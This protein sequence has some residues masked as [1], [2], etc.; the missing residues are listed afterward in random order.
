M[1]VEYEPLALGGFVVAAVLIWNWIRVRIRVR[2][3]ET[4]VQKML[5]EISLLQIQESRRLI[6][7]LNVKSTEKIE[8]PETAQ[9]PSVKA[10]A[11]HKIRSAATPLPPPQ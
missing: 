7:E 3:I 1:I 8:P 4:Q 6:I 9:D 10:V 5:K 2:R 11:T